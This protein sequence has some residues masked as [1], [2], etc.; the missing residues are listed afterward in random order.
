MARNFFFVSFGLLCVVASY[1]LGADTA[2]ADWDRSLAGSVTGAQYDHVFDS[3]GHAWTIN[4]YFGPVS[5]AP[6]R[7]LVV[8]ENRNDANLTPPADDS[9]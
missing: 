1:Q 8:S 3:D 4:P 6:E 2:R 9:S 5:R 7:D